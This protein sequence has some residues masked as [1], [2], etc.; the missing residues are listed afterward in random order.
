MQRTFASDN[1]QVTFSYEG[2]VT[3]W[4]LSISVSTRTLYCLVNRATKARYSRFTLRMRSSK[5]VINDSANLTLGL[6]DLSHGGMVEIS[7]AFP[8]KRRLS[9]VIVRHRFRDTE[10]TILLPQDAPILA[11]IGYLKP[12]KFGSMCE[13]QLWHGLR[14]TG[15]GVLRGRALKNTHILASYGYSPTYKFDCDTWT[16]RVGGKQRENETSRYLNRLDVL[17]ELFNVFINRASSFDTSVSLVLG[18][19]TFSDKASVKQE[20]TP[21]F[22]SF[23]RQLEK[24]FAGG[25][26]VVYD[27]LDAAQRMLTN[28][29]SDLPQLRK[30]I[31]IVTDGED[32]GSEASAKDV[33]LALQ[34]SGIIVDSVQVGLQS[35][36]KLHAISVATGGYRFCPQTSLSDALSIF[37]LETMLSSAERTPRLSKRPVLHG[38]MLR[39]YGNTLDFPV[40]VVTISQFPHRAPHAKLQQSVQPAAKLTSASPTHNDRTKRIMRELKAFIAD[41]HPQIDLY[42]NDSDMSFLKIILEAPKDET[43]CPYRNGTFLL[44]CDIPQNYPREPPE[45]RFVTFI[46]HPNVSKQGKVCVAELGRLWSSDIT[47]KEIFSLIYGLL[48]EPD[49]ENPLEI[50]ASLKYYDDDGTFALAV[51]DAVDK[52]ASKSRDDWRLELA[53][54]D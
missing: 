43:E 13:M 19:V 7:F 42:V 18:L 17:K 9:E 30:R 11:L 3:V 21:I 28:Y 49:L 12:T 46:L 8:H 34:R 50:Q 40:D 31:I 4:D 16:W 14:E 2:K 23:R 48:L 54:A 10:Q 15:D 26:T 33:C 35:D 52:H 27:A 38:N 22:E 45:I 25:N 51:A 44:T 39:R 1:V 37:D 20:L 5:A 53:N 41:P 29:R 36:N 47:L 24:V 6:T 32:T